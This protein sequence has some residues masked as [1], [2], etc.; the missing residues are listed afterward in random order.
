MRYINLILT[1]LLTVFIS[2]CHFLIMLN[3]HTLYVYLESLHGL[4]LL[5]KKCMDQQLN[6]QAIGC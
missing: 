3:N 2:V 1:Y 6:S 4:E 5:L